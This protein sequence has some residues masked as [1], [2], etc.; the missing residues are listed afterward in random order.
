MNRRLSTGPQEG[1]FLTEL[2]RRQ[3]PVFS[4]NKHRGIFRTL[5]DR[6]LHE[7][8]R[9]LTIKGWLLHV[10]RGTYVVVPRAAQRTWREH[11]FV[12]AAALAPD[13]YYISY[14][15]AL[16]FHHLT[17]QM[18]QSVVVVTRDQRKAPT[19]FQG[20]TYRFITRPQRTFFGIGQYE[21]TALNGA[22]QVPVCVADPEKSVLDGLSNDRPAGGMDELIKAL[23]T[24]IK[25]GQLTVSRLVAYA[26]EYPNRAVGQRLGYILSRCGLAEAELDPLRSAVRRTGYPPYLAGGSARTPAMRDQEWNLMVNVPDHIF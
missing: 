25:S 21:L 4:L 7:V 19:I 23:R 1:A 18:P 20:T 24:G 8:L 11:P 16:S 17:E 13:P 2:E 5:E 3:I 22:A 10:E 15:A 9:G 12:I 6:T 26:D 14:W